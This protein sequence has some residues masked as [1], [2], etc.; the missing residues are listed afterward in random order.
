[1]AGSTPKPKPKPKVF[2]QAQVDKLLREARK[3]AAN[4]IPSKQAQQKMKKKLKEQN[5]DKKMR[6]AAKKARKKKL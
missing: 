5:L 3:E 1:M 6:E 4:P 2:T